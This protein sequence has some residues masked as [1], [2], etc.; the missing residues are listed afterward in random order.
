[1]PTDE[2]GTIPFI[3]VDIFSSDLYDD[4]STDRSWYGGTGTGTGTPLTC[5]PFSRTSGAVY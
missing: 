2:W 1:M 4:G 3:V 5:V